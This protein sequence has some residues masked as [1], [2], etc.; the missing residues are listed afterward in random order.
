MNLNFQSVE[1]YRGGTNPLSPPLTLPEHCH[2]VANPPFK[3]LLIILSRRAL[4]NAKYHFSKNPLS[5]KFPRHYN[6]SPEGLEKW[7]LCR[8]IGHYF[9]PLATVM[10]NGSA[11]NTQRPCRCHRLT[12]EVWSTDQREGESAE[13]RA[14]GGGGGKQ[15]LSIKQTHTYTHFLSVYWQMYWFWWRQLD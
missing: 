10:N 12:E 11:P 14:R 8:L 15:E 4:F 5:Q 9:L 7:S 3:S 6:E 1:R 13:R 2:E